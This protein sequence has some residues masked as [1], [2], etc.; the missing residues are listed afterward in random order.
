MYNCFDIANSK[1][2]VQNFTLI[3][4]KD[5]KELSHDIWATKCKTNQN[6]FSSH[7]RDSKIPRMS[8]I[9]VGMGTYWL[10]CILFQFQIRPNHRTHP[11][12]KILY[13]LLIPSHFLFGLWW[14]WWHD[15]MENIGNIKF[16]IL[17][18]MCTLTMLPKE[19]SDVWYLK[20]NFA[21][22]SSV[23][24]QVCSH[25]NRFESYI[26]NSICVLTNHGSTS[27]ITKWIREGFQEWRKL[28]QVRN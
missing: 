9:R 27:V 11:I 10:I 15:D 22:F 19:F 18:I 2:N 21:M 14:Q 6:D 17:Y 13:W 7:K 25:Q 4:F 1:Q 28:E 5:K 20:D 16:K 8:S 26:F 12:N 3:Y 23:L 24:Q